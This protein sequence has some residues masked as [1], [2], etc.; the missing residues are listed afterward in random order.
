LYGYRSVPFLREFHGWIDVLSIQ[1][2]AF[3]YTSPFVLQ[4]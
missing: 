1:E 4:E 3:K 2:K